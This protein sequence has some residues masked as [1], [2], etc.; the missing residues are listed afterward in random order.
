MTAHQ[1]S[2]EQAWNVADQLQHLVREQQPT[3]MR[4]RWPRYQEAIEAAN[5]LDDARRERIEQSA[6]GSSLLW[7]A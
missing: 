5:Q 6:E 3:A 1:Q 4:R 7:A 2:S